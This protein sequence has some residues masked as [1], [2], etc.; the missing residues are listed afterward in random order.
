MLIIYRKSDG[1]PML[2]ESISSFFTK[3]TYDASLNYKH[4]IS[5]HG[6][7]KDEYAEIWVENE[8]IERRTLTHEFSIANDEI[9]FGE[10]KVIEEIQQEPSEIEKLQQ[11]NILLKAQNQALSDRTDFHEDVLSEIILTMYS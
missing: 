7:V 6:G 11:E 3:E 9:V 4:I 2:Q 1:K 5:N 8:E 10:E